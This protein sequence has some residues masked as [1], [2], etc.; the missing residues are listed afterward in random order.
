MSRRKA[1]YDVGRSRVHCSPLEKSGSVCLSFPP[2]S[3][4]PGPLQHRSSKNTGAGTS[5]AVGGAERAGGTVDLVVGSC[6]RMSQ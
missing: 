1:V 5:L 4:T 3:M 2:T 6:Q